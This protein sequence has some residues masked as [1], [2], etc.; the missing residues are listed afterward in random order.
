M[1]R[2]PL[3]TVAAEQTLTVRMTAHDRALLDALVAAR[4]AERAE[5]GEDSTTAAGYL[6]AF[7]RREARAKGITVPVPESAAKTEA[8][9]ATAPLAPAALN[10]E[11][12]GI[13]AALLR[14]VEAATE[15]QASIA[16][17]A[18]IDAGALSRFVKSG[19]GLSKEKLKALGKALR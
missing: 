17:R 4:N 8:P 2:K 12:A 7:I 9:P 16:R 11:T 19:K 15:S 1:S 18:G 5:E 10:K 3:S 6:R 14:K 13:H